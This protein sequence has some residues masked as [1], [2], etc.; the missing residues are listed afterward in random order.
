MNKRMQIG[1][2]DIV[3]FIPGCCRKNDIG[4]KPGAGDPKIN[5]DQKVGLA[6]WRLLL[7][8]NVLRRPRMLCIGQHRIVPANQMLDK[9]FMPLAGG[10]EEVRPPDKQVAR[11][12]DRIVW[13]LAGKFQTARL[14]AR[15]EKFARFEPGTFRRGG[16]P[17]GIG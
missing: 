2:A 17:Q 9:I 1:T 3:F 12:I 13:I 5:T 8:M 6:L 10:T 14:K 15:S 16:K 4:E 7:N 11:E